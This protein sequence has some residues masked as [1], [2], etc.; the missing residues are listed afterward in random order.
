MLRGYVT[1]CHNC[2]WNLRPQRTEN[3]RS[4]FETLNANLGA[5]QGRSLL[6]QVLRQG[7]TRPRLQF[8]HM[9][10][11]M[12]AAWVLA[13]GITLA[14]LGMW[15]FW[16]GRT[17]W[18]AIPLG[19]LFLGLGWV[20]R[21][22]FDQPPLDYLPAEEY[23]ALYALVNK[24]ASTLQAPPVERIYL[25]PWLNASASREGWR[26]SPSLY[27]G[28]PLWS[29]L[30]DSEKLALLSHELAHLV[31]GD[32][33]RG[34]LTGAALDI[35]GRWYA[36]LRPS[37]KAVEQTGLPVLA[38]VPINLA[39]ST[40]SL[41]VWLHALALTALLWR[42]QQRAEYYADTLAAEV[43]GSYPMLS[44]LE[45][46]HHSRTFQSALGAWCLNPELQESDFF[47]YL[48]R[49]I[50]ALPER[51]LE[52]V[53]QVELLETSRLDT[54]HPPT[55]YRVHALQ[56]ALPP[57]PAV[58]I[59]PGELDWQS[60]DTALASAYRRVELELQNNYLSKLYRGG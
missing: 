2:G 41:A 38:M 37:G 10:S 21:P 40:L 4:P 23:P 59:S 43:C 39:L 47:T 8:A 32:P 30:E 25:R 17:S 20:M 56:A 50:T 9:L 58:L 11:V 7:A 52:R 24:V 29:V 49:R 13:S 22:R 46:L 53:R 15:L 27:L 57:D 55:A 31:N 5:R 60:V 28:L 45:K 44:L 3:G 16:Q 42:D 1:W 33:S 34:A 54:R 6:L 19:L 35:L 48:R 12:L 36:L 26:R 51:E 14:V 18:W